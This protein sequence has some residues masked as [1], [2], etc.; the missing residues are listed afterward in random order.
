MLPLSSLVL[1]LSCCVV[2]HC[3]GLTFLC[4]SRFIHRVFFTYFCQCLAFCSLLPHEGV[5][6]SY[7]II[8]DLCL[9]FLPLHYLTFPL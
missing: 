8:I 1:L 4:W 5:S 3:R 7:L 6:P 2:G 9:N